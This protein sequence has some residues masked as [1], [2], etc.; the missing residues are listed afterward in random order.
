MIIFYPSLPAVGKVGRGELK[1][2]FKFRA[3]LGR[4]WRAGP[5]WPQLTCPRAR[6]ITL[7]CPPLAT[8]LHQAAAG[9]RATSQAVPY[10]PTLWFAG[11][12][13]V[14]LLASP[15]SAAPIV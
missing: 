9:R 13:A 7:T 14:P 10:S 1:S 2:G 3:R 15:P 5:G 6:Y 11:P 8:E 12:P 4:A